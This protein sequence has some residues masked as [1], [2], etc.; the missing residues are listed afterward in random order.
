MEHHLLRILVVILPTEPTLARP[1]SH[2]HKN[3]PYVSLGHQLSGNVVLIT[4]LAGPCATLYVIRV[5]MARLPF[6]C[7][8]YH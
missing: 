4:T 6:L 7:R 2:V 8:C 5:E 3:F 1:S